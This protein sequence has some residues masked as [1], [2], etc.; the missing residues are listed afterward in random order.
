MLCNLY[1]IRLL[2]NSK[3]NPSVI[4]KAKYWNQTLII[5]LTSKVWLHERWSNN[6]LEPLALTM[7][8][9]SYNAPYNQM[10]CHIPFFLYHNRIETLPQNCLYGV[11]RPCMKDSESDLILKL[12]YNV[13]RNTE[14]AAIA[15][16][17]DGTLFLRTMH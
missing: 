4:W 16:R 12:L 14:I 17:E 15:I 3:G 2:V 11:A 5:Y 10:T 6:Y 9:H 1:S 7:V 8:A 13:L